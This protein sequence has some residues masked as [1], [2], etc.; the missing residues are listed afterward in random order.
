[1]Q[2]VHNA[3]QVGSADSYD[4]KRDWTRYN[5]GL[6][7][8]ITLNPQAVGLVWSA[9]MH[10]VSGGGVAFWCK[11]KIPIH[12]TVYVREWQESVPLPWLAAKVM[13]TTVGIRGFLIGVNFLEPA[14]A[15]KPA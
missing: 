15:E 11:Q 12:S 8:E 2:L 13:H 4:G 9:I 10:N 1:M 14:P 5:A 3:K 6:Q 7:L